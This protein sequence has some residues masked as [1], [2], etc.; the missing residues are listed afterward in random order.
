MF[1][2][3]RSTDT[4]SWRISVD[5]QKRSIVLPD[6]RQLSEIRAGAVSESKLPYRAVRAFYGRVEAASRESVRMQIALSLCDA[7]IRETR[8]RG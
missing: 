8:S 3:Q 5:A 4:L 2:R 6:G 1:G 7:E